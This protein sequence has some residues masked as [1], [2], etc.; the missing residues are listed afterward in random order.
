MTVCRYPAMCSTVRTSSTEPG[1][2]RSGRAGDR[3][4]DPRPTSFLRA[5]RRGPISPGPSRHGRRSRR[6]ARTRTAAR[7]TRNA[8][9]ETVEAIL[10]LTLP[11]RAS[12][13]AD[14][15]C[16]FA[17]IRRS[18]LREVKMLFAHRG[19]AGERRASRPGDAETLK[20]VTFARRTLARPRLR[21]SSSAAPHRCDRCGTPSAGPL[22]SRADFGA[23]PRRLGCANAS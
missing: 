14:L 13:D 6:V 5:S 20:R 7:T 8:T 22:R 23:I 16:A 1:R 12:Y 4:Y 10:D 3:F 18:P 17:R 2:V 21:S 9:G 15:R 11:H 19:R